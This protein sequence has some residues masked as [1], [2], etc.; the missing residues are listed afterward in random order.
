MTKLSKLLPALA[1]VLFGLG[2][3][4]WGGSFLFGILKPAAAVLVI[5]VFL[6]ELMPKDSEPTSYRAGAGSPHGGHGK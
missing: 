1:V 2:C 4:P 5:V 3:T 6:Q